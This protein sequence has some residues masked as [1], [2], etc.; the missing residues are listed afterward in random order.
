MVESE[1]VRKTTIRTHLVETIEWM[2]HRKDN[3][4][5]QVR[6]HAKGY[7]VDG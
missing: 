4:G 1:V 7:I 2:K 5:A 6:T 3:C